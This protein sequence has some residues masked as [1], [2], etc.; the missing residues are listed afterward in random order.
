MREQEI[1]QRLSQTEDMW[2][3]RA[4][5][6]QVALCDAALGAVVTHAVQVQVDFKGREG[7]MVLKPKETRDIIDALE[8][9]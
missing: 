4:F 2:N 7:C 1:E 8:G 3:D 9:A 5:A 6:F